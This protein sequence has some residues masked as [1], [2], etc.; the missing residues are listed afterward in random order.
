MDAER[1]R[2]RVEILA[3]LAE[4]DASLARGEGRSIT[5]NSMKALAQDIKQ[6]GRARLAAD[7]PAS[8]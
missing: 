6:R 8:R 4:A 7:R 1:E 3:A 2:K 5:E